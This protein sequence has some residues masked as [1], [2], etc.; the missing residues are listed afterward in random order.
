LQ[1]AVAS[2]KSGTFQN[3]LRIY[4]RDK[5]GVGWHLFE[6]LR[7]IVRARYRHQS[8]YSDHDSSEKFTSDHT[9]KNLVSANLHILPH[10]TIQKSM[11]PR[12]GTACPDFSYEGGKNILGSDHMPL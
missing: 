5:I 1:R 3:G 11:R 12:N 10:K 9:F 2:H 6:Q 4:K 8:N 7:F